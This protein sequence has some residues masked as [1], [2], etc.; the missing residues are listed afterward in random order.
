MLFRRRARPRLGRVFGTGG[1]FVRR[2]R[3]VFLREVVAVSH[4]YIRYGPDAS[5]GRSPDAGRT[6][7]GNT[8]HL[9]AAPAGAT[10][11]GPWGRRRLSGLSG[12]IPHNGER[13]W[14]RGAYEVGRGD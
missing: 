1:P 13:P 9:A 8:R 12:P 3:Q 4:A 7:F 14:L 2:L 11:A 10:G 5:P 6:R